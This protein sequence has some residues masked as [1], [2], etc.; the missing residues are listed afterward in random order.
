[1]LKL[2]REEIEKVKDIIIDYHELSVMSENY[3]KQLDVIQGHM[4]MIAQDLENLKVQEDELMDVLH[5][6]YGD[7]SF[8]DLLDLISKELEDGIAKRNTGTVEGQNFSDFI[9]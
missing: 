1:M 2:E 7:F 6:K 9:E 5:K 3:K 4:G 8:Q